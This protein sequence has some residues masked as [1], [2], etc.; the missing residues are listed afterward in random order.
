MRKRLPLAFSSVTLVT[1]VSG[2]ACGP[3]VVHGHA[4]ID[5][6]GAGHGFKGLSVH[7]DTLSLVSDDGIVDVDRSGHLIE[8][9]KAGEHG[10]VAEAYGD[11]SVIDAGADAP[12]YVLISN[13]EGSVYDPATETQASRFC[14]LPGGDLAPRIP[15]N[16]AVAVSGATILTSPR[17]Y[18]D[19]NTLLSSSLRTYQLTDGALIGEVALEGNPELTGIAVFL[20][21]ILGVEKSTLHVLNKLARRDHD[22]AL[23]GA[24]DAAGIAVDESR[25]EALV[26]DQSGVITVYA[27]ADL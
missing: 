21:G 13:S 24:H 1:L 7:N 17:F 23:D 3:V 15:K 2:A 9:H 8:L 20:G 22:V 4:T 18:D 12:Q 27:L 5:V 16:D 6:A 14:L 10:L 26:L 11:V 25:G 19:N